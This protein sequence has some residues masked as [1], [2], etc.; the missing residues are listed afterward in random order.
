MRQQTGFSLIEVMIALVVLGFG[1]LAM[2]KMQL[3]MSLATQWSRQ[4]ADATLMATNV[5]ERA[6]SVGCVASP[7]TAQT[8]AMQA[9]TRYKMQVDCSPVMKVTVRWSDTRTQGEDPD[10]RVVLVSQF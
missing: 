1:L 2:T 3:N 9:S 8:A 7:E 4:R 10:N 6:R 5:I